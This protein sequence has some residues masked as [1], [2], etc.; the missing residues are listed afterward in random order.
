MGALRAARTGISELG[1]AL[2]LWAATNYRLWEVGSASALMCILFHQKDV[3]PS[4]ASWGFDGWDMH[5][6][7]ILRLLFKFGI[8]NTQN[9][10]T[11][12]TLKKKKKVDKLRFLIEPFFNTSCP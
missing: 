3:L 6:L 4:W 2:S 5:G 1:A 11:T 12:V 8:D 9:N 10:P 7:E